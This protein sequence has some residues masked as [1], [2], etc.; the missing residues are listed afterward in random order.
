[1]SNLYMPTRYKTGKACLAIITAFLVGSMAGMV[2]AAGPDGDGITLEQYEQFFGLERTPEGV[3]PKWL[4]G[5]AVDHSGEWQT[6]PPPLAFHVS[7]SQAENTGV[8]SLQVNRSALA[9][10]DLVLALT[11]DAGDQEEKG[12]LFIGLSSWP[13]GAEASEDGAILPADLFGNI[14]QGQEEITTAYFEIPIQSIAA[15]SLSIDIYRGTGEIAISRAVLYTKTEFNYWLEQALVE[16][17]APDVASAGQESEDLA[18]ADLAGGTSLTP[19][20]SAVGGPA[21]QPAAPV[22][23]P[24][25]Q[26]ATALQ[27]AANYMIITRSALSGGGGTRQTSPFFIMEDSFAQEAAIGFSSGGNFNLQSGFQQAEAEQLEFWNVS[28]TPAPYQQQDRRFNPRLGETATLSYVLSTSARTIT[29]GV[30]DPSGQLVR[31][32]VAQQPQNIGL[33]TVAWDGRDANNDLAP[34]GT[35]QFYLNGTNYDA[36][37]ANYANAISIEVNTNIAIIYS[38][39]DQPDPFAPPADSTISYVT[40]APLG[41]TDL[42]MTVEIFADNLGGRLIRRWNRNSQPIGSDSVIWDGTDAL[43]VNAPDGIY[44]YSIWN[45]DGLPKRPNSKSGAITL[46]RNNTQTVVSPDGRVEVRYPAASTITI[47]LAG[48][49]DVSSAL[50]TIQAQAPRL[51]LQSLIYRVEAAPPT[52]FT[53][54]ALMAFE[55]DPAI[56][57][58]IEEK[59]QLRRYNA[60]TWVWDLVPVQFGDYSNNRIIAEVVTNLSLFALFASEAPAAPAVLKASVRLKPEVLKVSPGILTAFVRLPE[61][62]PASGITYAT[63]DGALYERMMLS[64]DGTEIVIKFRRRDIEVTLAVTGETMDIYFIIRGA[65][66]D[67][68]GVFHAFQGWDSITK[69]VGK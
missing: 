60:T 2:L 63:C 5:V 67:E 68:A 12:S 44:A 65:W 69:I 21:H 36:V 27:L 58:D 55:Y 10:E 49:A 31:N 19:K 45:R 17:A 33:N 32:L 30:Y 52:T 3:W 35:Y 47:A 37:G 40:R 18:G 14:M 34:V 64:S 11:Y 15:Q 16:G 4:L 50:F 26:I 53:Q 9:G 66:Q 38:V 57:G 41:I 23:L 51:I 54:P 48:P 43:G 56:S 6:D 59:L 1:M 8:L 22:A 29:V 28:V 62:Y 39:D 25:E 7:A 13:E 20:P 24:A 46:L 42:N 61:G